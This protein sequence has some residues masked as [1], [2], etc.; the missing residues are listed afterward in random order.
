MAKVEIVEPRE[1]V[2][3]SN[4]F[5]RSRCKIKDVVAGRILMAFASLVDETDINENGSFLEYRISASSVLP[6]TSVGGDNYKQVRDAAYTLLDQKLERKIGKNGFQLYT[7]FS[8]IKY[9]NGI[10][11]GEF[12]KD[13]K[14][15]F[16]GLQ[17]KFTQLHLQQYMKLPSIYSQKIYLLLKSWDDKPEFIIKLKDL[18]ETLHTPESFRKNFK[19]FR[20]WVLEKSHKD[21]TSKTSLYYE[22]EPIK[23]GRAVNEIRFIF[24]KKRTLPVARKKEDNAIEKQRQK[25][26]ALGQQAIN[27]LKEHGAACE[28]GHQK[29]AVCEVCRKIR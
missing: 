8:T 29:E 9:E 5:V 3:A 6:Y 20:R 18:Q 22:W 23:K 26:Q 10:I 7:L 13:L 1:I 24:S 4:D 21:I 14:P 12:H 17:E 19:E 27:C 28:G 15:F 25:R 16:L 11:T 2:K